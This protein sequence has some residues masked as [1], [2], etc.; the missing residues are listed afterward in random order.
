MPTCHRRADVPRRK[1][2]G[3]TKNSA[4]KN[5]NQKIFS[6]IS[7]AT[8]TLLTLNNSNRVNEH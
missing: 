5:I 4:L 8:K 2:S 6:L 7:K 1:L 3:N